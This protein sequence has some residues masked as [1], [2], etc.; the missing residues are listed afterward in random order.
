MQTLFKFDD[1]ELDAT[2]F[3][4]RRGPSRVQIQPKQLRLLL[5]LIL[6]RERTVPSDELFRVLWPTVTVC[7]GSLKRAVRGARRALGD[8]GESQARIRTVRG[9]GYRFVQ[10]LA[11]ERADAAADHGV[12]AASA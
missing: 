3:E 4:L 9:Y 12:A 1:F 6:H 7:R 11:H 2:C 10:P 5:Y 8:D